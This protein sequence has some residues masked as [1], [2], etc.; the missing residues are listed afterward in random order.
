MPMDLRSDTERRALAVE[1]GRDVLGDLN[2]VVAKRQLA[3][4]QALDV[5]S[6]ELYDL[7]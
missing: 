2:R 6:E 3:A 5:L 1:V 4:Q 7:G